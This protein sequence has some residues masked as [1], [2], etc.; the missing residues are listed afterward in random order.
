MASATWT[1]HLAW[2]L[3]FLYL[4]AP[5]SEAGEVAFSHQAA[6]STEEGRHLS[7]IGL[8][9]G[10]EEGGHVSILHRPLNTGDF[11]S[12]EA[13]VRGGVFDSYIPGEY[14]LPPGLEYYLSA[15]DEDGEEHRYPEGAP[16]AS[17]YQVSVLA[18]SVVDRLG[19]SPQVKIVAPEAN[20]RLEAKDLVF[21]ASFEDADGDLDATGLHLIV[22]GRDRSHEAQVD[23]TLLIW[24]PGADLPPGPLRI[25][26]EAVDLSG[27]R[28]ITH[29]LK[30][31]LLRP[32]ESYATPGFFQRV[33][34]PRGRVILDSRFTNLEGLGAEN[35]QEPD[36]TLRGR[37]D[38][39]GNLG[40]LDY[41]AKV[42]MT[43]D[44]SSDMQPRNRYRLDLETGPLRLS[45]GDVSPRFNPLLI[46]GKRMRG[47]ELELESKTLDA[48]LLFGSIQRAVEGETS[49]STLAP[50]SYKRQLKALRIGSVTGR[51]VGMS[52]SF[53]K[54]KDDLGSI[55]YGHKPKDNIVLGADMEVATFG[56]H[57]LLDAAAAVSMLTEDISGGALSREEADSTLG[58]HLPFDPR[59][60]EGLLVINGSTTPLNFKGA[61][62]LALHAAARGNILG[63][64]MELRFRRVGPVYHSLAATALPQDHQGFL[65][66]DSFGLMQRRIRVSG[67]YERYHDNLANDKTHTRE[68]N[69]I[70]GNLSY[71]PRSSVLSGLSVGFRLYRQ[72]NGSSLE[73]DGIDN[74]TLLLTFSGNSNFLLRDFSESLRLSLFLSNR[75]DYISESGESQGMNLVLESRTGLPNI[76]LA[77]GFL[78][79]LSN[80]SYPGLEDEGGQL[81]ISADFTTLQAGLDYDRPRMPVHFTWRRVSGDGDMSG[82]NSLRS[83]FDLAMDYRFETGP[84]LT[85]RAGWVSFDDR[86]EGD[87]DYTEAFLGIGIEQPF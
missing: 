43:S 12:I 48:Q 59:N 23:G 7:I 75:A 26:V 50:G 27:H 14:L 40:I 74:R 63:N 20:V 60:L 41:R 15:V 76:P 72:S 49:D 64:L 4:Y 28:T 42:F 22:N 3:L 61:P 24:M 39:R 85:G 29:P 6:L 46:W 68:S 71:M 5:A 45:I 78:V 18:G 2:L 67:E 66:R 77:L 83:S 73:T 80:N 13:Y 51:A 16:E 86:S 84:V 10:I 54:V 17:T 19:S 79:G 36:R 32:G 53:L 31:D 11:E 47:M 37:L 34:P 8:V 70:A 30:L 69:V 25:E 55:K 65:L 33:A 35:R 1:R 62:N 57:L 44:E 52:L 87:E 82:A 56:R 58:I 21:I 81:G 9:A 38:A